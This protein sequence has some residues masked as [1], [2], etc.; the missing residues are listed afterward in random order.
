MV[1]Q[2]TGYNYLTDEQIEAAEA[3]KK[4]EQERETAYQ[5][6]QLRFTYFVAEL[7]MLSRKYGVAIQSTGGVCF[8]DF[9]G[10]EYSNDASS[11]DLTFNI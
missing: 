2:F 8:G 7:A 6:K 9:E 5:L 4:R 11:G 1:K 3:A 10:I